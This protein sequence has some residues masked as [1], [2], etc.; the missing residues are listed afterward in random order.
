MI[1]LCDD[2]RVAGGKTSLVMTSLGVR[3]QY[4][5]LL[6][7]Q[8]RY[9]DTKTFAGGFQ[10]LV[11]NYGT[12]VPVVEDVDHPPG[13]MHFLDEKKLRVY[14]SREWHWMDDDGHTVKWV[15][16]YDSWQAILRQYSEFATSQRNAHGR[17]EDIIE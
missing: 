13:Q 1:E 2:I 10:G 12:E 8:R 5:A 6:T 16:D 3:R 7:Q 4:F 17:L 9:S 14:R 15:D 11:F